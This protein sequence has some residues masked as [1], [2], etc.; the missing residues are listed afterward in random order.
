MFSSHK[1]NSNVENKTQI[2]GKTNIA[3]FEI[4]SDLMQ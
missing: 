2:D 4:K 3:I 1:E